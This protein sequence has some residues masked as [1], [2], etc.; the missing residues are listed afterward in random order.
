MSASEIDRFTN[1]MKT[2]SDLLDEV[3]Q[4]SGT[5]AK[6]V[7]FADGRGYKFSL[8]EAKEYLDSKAG[9]ELDDAQLDAVAGGKGHKTSLPAGS[10]TSNV[11]IQTTVN[12]TTV[13]AVAE[14]EVGVAAVAAAAA[15]VAA[16]AVAVIILT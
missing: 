12:V 2:D 13:A 11:N 4:H 10:V 6:V 5:L 8:E 15:D 16:V 14:V 9:K 7:A 1:D 3:K